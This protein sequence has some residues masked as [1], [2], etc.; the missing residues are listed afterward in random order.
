MLLIIGNRTSIR[1]Q[2]FTANIAH[3][4]TWIQNKF[5][6]KIPIP[7]CLLIFSAKNWWRERDYKDCFIKIT[8]QICPTSILLWALYRESVKQ[9][10]ESWV[11][12]II[13]IGG[14]CR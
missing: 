3:A 10:L 8:S 7:C 11:Y 5:G 12:I 6:S 14:S 9:I 1:L 4:K 13:N 2:N